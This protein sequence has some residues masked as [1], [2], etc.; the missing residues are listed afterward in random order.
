MR[1]GCVLVPVN[2]SGDMLASQ[3]QTSDTFMQLTIS[4]LDFADNKLW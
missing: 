3:G 4:N 2:W 1:A